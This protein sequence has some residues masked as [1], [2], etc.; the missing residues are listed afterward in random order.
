MKTAATQQSLT[1]NVTSVLHSA[2]LSRFL[3]D[4]DISLFSVDLLKTQ[5]TFEVF[6]EMYTIPDELNIYYEGARIFS[7]GGLVSGS[8]TTQ[9][10][11][12]SA[13]STRTTVTVEINAPN[14]GTAW[15]IRVGCPP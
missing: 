9:V 1:V 8:M 2:Q 13:T 15:V 5:G 10:S 14:A 6:Y 11:Y 12:G 7:T 3:A 4:K